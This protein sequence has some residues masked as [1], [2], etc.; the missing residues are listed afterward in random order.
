MV[1][2]VLWSGAVAFWLA[3]LALAVI[4]NIVIRKWLH[5]D[6]KERIK[7]L[8]DEV[9]RRTQENTELMEQVQVAWRQA[10]RE[11]RR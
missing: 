9:D 5:D 8:E 10:A 4:L 3:T 6:Y 1:Q 11:R 2:F 7:K